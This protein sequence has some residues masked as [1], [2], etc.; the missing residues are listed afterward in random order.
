M[1][2]IVIHLKD[3]A[4]TWAEA[5]KSWATRERRGGEG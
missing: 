5:F 2:Y 4:Q 3:D 1:A